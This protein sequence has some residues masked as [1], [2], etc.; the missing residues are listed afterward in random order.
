MKFSFK[1]IFSK[2][3]QIP[4]DLVTLTEEILNGSIFKGFLLK[5]A[6]VSYINEILT[7]PACK[8]LKF[9]I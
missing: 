4:A 5:A 8:L 6:K 2:C 3:D 7:P 9:F 1:D